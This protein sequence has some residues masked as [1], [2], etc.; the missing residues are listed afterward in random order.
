MRR[1]GR[2]ISI[3]LVC[4]VLAFGHR[5]TL[6]GQQPPQ[7]VTLALVGGMLL[8][9]WGGPPVHHATVVITAKRIVA[10]GAASEIVVPKDATIIDAIGRT[11]MPGL[12]EAH[13]H[14]FILGHGE[15]SR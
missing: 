7:A 1:A 2:R 10:A 3:V 8:D 13:A 4:A 5:P 11:I 9:G 12:I 15:Y 6:S 14:L